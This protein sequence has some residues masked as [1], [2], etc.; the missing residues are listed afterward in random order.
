VPPS[1]AAFGRFDASRAHGAGLTVTPIET[2]FRECWDWLN[3]DEEVAS[4]PDRGLDP[5]R[6]AEL[7]QAWHGRAADSRP[8][9]PG[10]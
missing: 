9:P 8:A 3:S 5:E 2:S 6:E 4:R 7:L 1:E 10:A